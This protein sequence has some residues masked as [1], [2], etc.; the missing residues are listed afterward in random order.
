MT[1]VDNSQDLLPTYEGE[2]DHPLCESLTRAQDALA[3]GEFISSVRGTFSNISTYQHLFVSGFELYVRN[4][5]KWSDSVDVAMS[6]GVFDGFHKG[7]QAL[8]DACKSYAKNHDLLSCVVTFDPDPSYVL[9]AKSPESCSLSTDASL[10][11]TH[12][13]LDALA[14]SSVDLIV[15][16]PFT[17]TLAHMSYQNFFS[18]LS[19]HIVHPVHLF[20]G[21]DFRIGN[22]GKGTVEALSAYGAHQQMDV[23]SFSLVTKDEG[24]IS[25]SRIRL[26]ISQGHL[27]CTARLLGHAYSVEGKV[28]HGRRQGRRLGFPTANILMKQNMCVPK[29]GVY[30]GFVQVEDTLYPA[31]INVGFP[32]TFI[33]QISAMQQKTALDHRG[34]IEAHLFDYTGDLY[35]TNVHVVFVAYIRPEKH[36]SSENTLKACVDDNIQTIKKLIGVAPR[37]VKRCV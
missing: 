20:V 33:Q 30:A 25:A 12:A 18:Y 22:Q 24:I 36:F 11:S 1:R 7:H 4:S 23:T 15:V 13:R 2:Q 29:S 27:L 34:F 31:A 37:Q 3:H 19:Y 8:I 10:M 5:L 6:I 32:P 21:S 9:S 14:H 17:Q 16:V 35:D 26:L 28:I